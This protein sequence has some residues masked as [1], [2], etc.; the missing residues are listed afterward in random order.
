MTQDVSG[1]PPAP[2]QPNGQVYLLGD[3]IDGDVLARLREG[4]SKL[5]GVEL[6][7]CDRRGQRLDQNGTPAPCQPCRFP[8]QHATP[9]KWKSHVLGCVV[10]LSPDPTP[11]Q[12]VAVALIADVLSDI[13]R[14]EARIRRH[15]SELSTIYDLGDLFAGGGDLK[16][17]LALAAR[18]I[19]EVMQVKASS[20][21]LLNASAGTL[22]IFATHNLS[23]RYLR[24]GPVT[25]K[26]NPIDA[27]AFDGEVVY[28]E[29]ARTDPRVRFRSHARA[30]G[31]VSGLC[32]PMSYRGHTVGV[33]RVYTGQ[34]QTFTR[35]DVDLLRAVA[36]QAAAAIV[37]SR[38][39][40]ESVAAEANERQIKYAAKV[41]RRMLPARPPSHPRIAFGQV[42]EPSLEVG[43]DFFDYLDLPQGNLGLAIADVVG[44]GLPGALMM[45]SVRA[46]LRA[47]ARSLFN[48]HEIVAEV[49][50]DMCRDTRVSEFATLLYGVFSPDGSRFTYCNAGH[51]P[52]LLLRGEA[53][54]PLRTGGLVIGVDPQTTFQHDIIELSAGDILVFYTDGVTEALDYDEQLFGLDRLQRSI[55]KYR[56]ESAG[57]MA[58]Q[59][60]W[61]VRRFAGL[62][63]QSDDISL[64]VAKVS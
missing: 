36:A 46:A 2:A 4:F 64:V 26:E 11:A 1:A 28:I 32:C 31:V 14:A 40:R 38:L 51:N 13:C 8:A 52:A 35:F 7:I 23:E 56:T 22:E 59:L 25:L 53:F 3:L 41:Q 9:V 17:I 5:A 60:L 33:L 43:G 37:H 57:T 18:R 27:A 44:K 20:I 16:P 47:H 62:M 48:I 15:V 24:K 55:L 39:Y 29:D 12:Q 30:E 34:R 42:Y 58:R 63:Q 49:N 50:R 45:A 21:R 10:S 19:C 61:D 6:A 54:T